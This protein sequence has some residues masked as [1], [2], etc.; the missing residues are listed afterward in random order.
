MKVVVATITLAIPYGDYEYEGEPKLDL[1][2]GIL[3]GICGT[4]LDYFVC[5][6]R[7]NG[8]AAIRVEFNSYS[9]TARKDIEAA[10]KQLAETLDTQGVLVFM[11][12]TNT[13]A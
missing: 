1:I 6:G 12:G 3:K 11:D 4:Q 10:A 5:A 9:N 7:K 13:T 2:D 8:F